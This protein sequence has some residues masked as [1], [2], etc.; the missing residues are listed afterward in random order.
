MASGA[1]DW[2]IPPAAVADSIGRHIRLRPRRASKSLVNLS[3]IVQIRDSDVLK[4]FSIYV[5]VERQDVRLQHLSLRNAGCL[6]TSGLHPRCKYRK[7]LVLAQLFWFKIF[8]SGDGGWGLRARARK[9]EQKLRAQGTAPQPTEGCETEAKGETEG[10]TAGGRKG[11][12]GVQSV[13]MG[14]PGLH[15]MLFIPT[16]A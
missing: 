16:F 3:R 9:R 14:G 4:R 15:M 10:R 13:Q 5:V 1:R 7:I 11:I 2:G 6:G 12:L 8:V